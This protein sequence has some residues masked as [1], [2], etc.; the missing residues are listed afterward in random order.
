M[1]TLR[2]KPGDYS[3]QRSVNSTAVAL[4]VPPL[5]AK[6]RSNEREVLTDLLTLSNKQEVNIKHHIDEVRDEL[7]FFKSAIDKLFMELQQVKQRQ[8]SLEQNTE[9]LKDH[10]DQSLHVFED[11]LDKLE[12]FSRRDNLK[13]FGISE[14]EEDSYETCAATIIHLLQEKIPGKVWQT[15]DIVRV[16][17]EKLR[18][19]GVSVASDLTE[20]QQSIIKC[21]RN[22]GVRAFYRGDRLVVGG[23]L[24]Q[25]TNRQ[26]EERENPRTN[27]S[28]SQHQAALQQQTDEYTLVTAQRNNGVRQHQSS[29][30]YLP[31][32]LR[33]CYLPLQSGDEEEDTSRLQADEELI[34]TN[35]ATRR[36]ATMENRHSKRI[37]HTPTTT[38]HTLG[39]ISNNLQIISNAILPTKCLAES[40]TTKTS[41]GD[42]TKGKDTLL[43]TSATEA[44]NS[45]TADVSECPPNSSVQ[46]SSPHPASVSPPSRDLET[47]HGVPVRTSR[48]DTRSTAARYAEKAKGTQLPMRDDSTCTPKRR[49]NKNRGASGKGK[50]QGSGQLHK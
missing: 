11:K 3:V 33:N 26:Q 37:Q 23:P 14:T 20:R 16:A 50:K 21:Y 45:Q 29:L 19:K 9:R 5:E 1:G 39:N 47:T 12:G 24:H 17:R 36:G 35:A 34:D 18:A 6:A 22:S 15:I 4:C 42:N 38:I 41:T 46:V 49:K 48:V 31:L 28:P 25:N 2:K 30:S 40:N 32:P 7:R 44:N 8:E 13:F 27:R 43:Y 10:V